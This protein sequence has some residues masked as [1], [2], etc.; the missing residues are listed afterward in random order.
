MAKISG[1]DGKVLIGSSVNIS[2][3][4]HN[5]GVVTIDTASAHGLATGDKVMISG[6]VGMTDINGEF[7]ATYI[8]ADSFSIV[9]TTSQTY[10]SAGTAQMCA[11][12]I[13]FTLDRQIGL[14]EVSDSSSTAG[15]DYLSDKLYEVDGSFDGFVEEGVNELELGSEVSLVLKE[16][17]ATYWSGSGIVT[18]IGESLTASGGDAVKASYKFKGNGA[19]ARTNS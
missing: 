14:K 17:S 18:S 1:K 12:I 19:W 11:S 3:A 2:A 13:S 5:T 6:V 9:K 15:K 16:A 4:T 10:S 7:M 8:D